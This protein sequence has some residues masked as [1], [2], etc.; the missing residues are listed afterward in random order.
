ML[1]NHEVNL[2]NSERMIFLYLEFY[3]HRNHQSRQFQKCKVWKTLIM[4]TLV[5]GVPPKLG[6]SPRKRTTYDKGSR[7]S[8]PRYTPGI[9]GWWWGKPQAGAVGVAWRTTSPGR[10]R[11]LESSTRKWGGCCLQKTTPLTQEEISFCCTKRLLL[12][13]AS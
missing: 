10:S 3:T 12:L 2:Q 4:F 13:K 6:H 9:P 11:S 1:E 5:G 8:I 7:W